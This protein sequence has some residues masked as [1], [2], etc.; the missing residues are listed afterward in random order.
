LETDFRVP[1]P[2]QH[3]RW[4]WELRASP[5][6]LWPLV[7]NTDRFNRDCGYPAVQVVAPP[8]GTGRRIT[9]ARRLRASTLGRPVEWEEIAFESVEPVRF[10][11]ERHYLSGPLA[12]VVWWCGL[13]PRADG[14]TTLTYDMRI[15]PASALVGAV[16]PFIIERRVRRPA[17]RV[18]KKYDEFA[19]AGLRAS[20]LAQKP[21]LA[22]G[23]A[24]RLAAAA[25]SL[26]TQAGQPAPLVER[27]VAHLAG[28]D[29]LSLA[30]LRPY[31]LADEWRAPRR[32]TL[33][34]FLHATRAG[35]LDFSWD[36]ICPHCR[37]AKAGQGSLAGLKP[38][39]HCD[40]CDVDFTANFDQSVE[41]AFTPNAAVRAV[42]RADYCV[43][44][45]QVTPHVLAQRRLRAGETLDLALA[46]AP[47]RYR[48]RV[49]G[50]AAQHAFCVDPSVP[51]LARIHLGDRAE[52]ETRVASTGTLTLVNPPDAD[53]L[54]L[55]ERVAWSDQSA[56][57]A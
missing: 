50:E 28:A 7:S 13:A 38:V 1:Q 46:L 36:L 51:V 32:D 54:A 19:L 6:A 42:P 43:G 8:P 3:F 33:H 30:R 23:G 4:I 11:V 29:D 35:L 47:G 53:R 22:E 37:G 2:E 14:G 57:A 56:T 15:R 12:W 24:A 48:V 21:R 17:E 45:P 34:L 26:T 9:N 41:L 55:V 10:G 44:G 39:A 20:R 27:L 49:A 31:A 18:F 52:A 5:G 40:T 16:L 25:K